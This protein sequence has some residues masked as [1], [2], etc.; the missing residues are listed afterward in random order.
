MP[1]YW[2]G[3]RAGRRL[4]PVRIE[5]LRDLIS[6]GRLRGLDKVSTDGKTFRPLA[7][8]PELVALFAAREAEAGKPESNGE[9]ERIMA[10]LNLL[11]SKPV[12]EVFGLNPDAPIDA[13]RASFFALVRRF[14]PERVPSEPQPGLRQA[15]NEMFQFLSRVM[16]QVEALNM[17]KNPPR[18]AAPRPP[19]A[20]GQ[21]EFIGWERRGDDRVYCEVECTLANAAQIFTGHKLVNLSNSGFFLASTRPAPPL[22]TQIEVTINFAPAARKVTARA[23]VVWE[24][25]VDDGKTPR[26]FGCRFSRLSED[27]KKFIQDFVRRAVAAGG[28]V[29]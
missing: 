15:Y 17:S 29:G 3:D 9:A 21:R 1:D 2:V 18:S 13:Y 19:P 6:G 20:F 8:F 5:V 28:A 24:N 10:E 7:E 22:G 25:Q 26:G 4:G 11:K 27:E 23:S 12:Y 14:Y 16:A